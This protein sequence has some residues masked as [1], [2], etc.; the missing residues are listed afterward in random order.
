MQSDH[1][2]VSCGYCSIS[3]TKAILKGL[4]DS[5]NGNK[6]CQICA[7][8]RP[9]ILSYCLHMLQRLVVSVVAVAM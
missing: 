7:L 8:H 4:Q 3:I 1:S 2:D 6:M 5:K 9:G